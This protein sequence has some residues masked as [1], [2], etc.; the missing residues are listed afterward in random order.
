MQLLN[1]DL[2]PIN[3]IHHKNQIK[4]SS[5]HKNS[6]LPPLWAKTVQQLRQKLFLCKAR[7]DFCLFYVAVT[8]TSNMNAGQLFSVPLMLCA[9]KLEKSKFNRPIDIKNDRSDTY[10]NIYANDGAVMWN[11]GDSVDFR[12]WDRRQRLERY[13]GGDISQFVLR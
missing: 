3:K 12:D 7:F 1:L 8:T 10:L 4:H 6:N 11:C 13:F 5:L 9:I 2:I